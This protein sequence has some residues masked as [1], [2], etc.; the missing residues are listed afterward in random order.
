MNDEHMR[1]RRG[2]ATTGEAST[3]STVTGLW[4]WASGFIAPKR[5]DFTAVAAICSTVVP[6]SVTWWLTQTAFI[7]MRVLPTPLYISRNVSRSA[8]GSPSSMPAMV[9]SRDPGPHL[10]GADD[11]HG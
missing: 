3:S 9:S 1:R 6:R 7:P 2:E 10:L 8:A 11:E 5:L 4:N